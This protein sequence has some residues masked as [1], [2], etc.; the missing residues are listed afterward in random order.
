MLHY[1]AVDFFAPL[2]ITPQLLVTGILK[3][4]IVSDLLYDLAASVTVSVYRWDSLKPQ[5]TKELNVFVVSIPKF[6]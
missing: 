1:F 3:L 2:L 6:Y 4:S 5:Y